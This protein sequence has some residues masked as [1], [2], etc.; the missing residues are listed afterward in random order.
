M[1]VSGTS[2]HNVAHV[3]VR[4]MSAS[5]SSN[6]PRPPS[7]RAPRCITAPAIRVVRK[8]TGPMK[9]ASTKK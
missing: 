2:V 4:A 6:V 8:M 7:A 3:V 1:T 9:A 5:V